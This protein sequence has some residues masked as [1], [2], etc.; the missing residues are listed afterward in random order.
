MHNETETKSLLERIK[1]LGDK[2]TQILLF[3]SFAFVAAVALKSD[4]AIS[5]SQ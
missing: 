3:L 2:S 4:R 5:E 1:Q